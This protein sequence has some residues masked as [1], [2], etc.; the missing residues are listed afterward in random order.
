MAVREQAGASVPISERTLTK[1][2]K[3]RQF[4][5]NYAGSNSTAQNKNSDLTGL[6]KPPIMNSNQTVDLVVIF[7]IFENTHITPHN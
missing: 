1:G 3:Q 4:W 7:K 5:K 6:S 2:L